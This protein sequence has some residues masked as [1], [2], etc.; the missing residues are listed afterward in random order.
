MSRPRLILTILVR[1]EADIIAQNVAWHLSQG[2][3]HVIVT[4]NGSSDGTSD[5]LRPFLQGG[6]LTLLHEPSDAYLQ[7][8]WTTRMALMARDELGADWIIC[9]DA[10]EFWRAPSG[11]LKDALPEGEDAPAML[12]CHRHN[13]I[14][15]RDALE[16]GPWA[17][18]LVYRAV[19]PPAMVAPPQ[20][21]EELHAIRFEHPYFQ[22]RLPPKMLFR[23]RGLTSIARG[24]HGGGYAGE[25][26]KADSAVEILHYPIRSRRAF[27]ASVRQIGGAMR[28]N[29][30]TALQTSWKYRRWLAMT[31]ASG[32]IWPA[33][34]EALPDRQ[35]LARD[36]EAGRL[37]RDLSM[38]EALA[39]LDVPAP[40]VEG[41]A[42]AVPAQRVEPGHM[43]SLLL[44][45][46]P[47]AGVDAALAELLIARGATP[48]LAPPR[49][50][51]SLGEAILVEMGRGGRDLRAAPKGWFDRP[52][53]R[54]YQQTL[55]EAL[56]ESFAD[57]N[58]AVVHG[59]ELAALLPLW[60]GIARDWQLGL[61]TVLAIGN[62]SQ[63]VRAWHR[64]TGLPLPI[65]ALIW[66]RRALDAERHSRGLPRVIVL[67]DDLLGDW[68][69]CAGA[70]EGQLGLTA[71]APHRAPDD[72]IEALISRLKA[73]SAATVNDALADPALPDFV[74][75]VFETLR[76]L[77]A[78]PETDHS[79]T[80]DR[81][82]ATLDQACALLGPA[83]ASSGE[84]EAEPALQGQ[85][86]A[87]E[88]S[89][90]LEAS[91]TQ[92]ARLT[93]L[94]RCRARLVAPSRPGLRQRAR[95][96]LSGSDADVRAV[97]EAPEF[98]AEWYRSTYPDV[99]AHGIDP[100]QHFLRFGAR[101]GRNPGPG[102]DTLRYY[103]ANP[104]VLECGALAFLHYIRH[105]REEGRA[106]FPAEPLPV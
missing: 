58:D 53:A 44:V 67:H 99:S 5:A 78:S 34:A 102:F 98:D 12:T 93:L 29:A 91:Q 11:N 25:A 1:D 97:R 74:K 30:G 62:P 19:D 90:A 35:R 70:L 28:R 94:L 77:A 4:D 76:A 31:E 32:S 101:E 59:P 80:L 50:L 88:T 10:D 92:N 79:T 23:A 7:D 40:M 86:D 13:M 8:A 24:A 39:Q 3:D 95:D 100:A 36:V 84:V 43:G 69:A 18:R 65:G 64:A 26:T 45:T 96:R 46:G 33:F 81:L 72:Q 14:C 85:P 22:Y 55:F 6:A 61:R 60:E 57:L 42:P 75:E 56:V 87:T 48:P 89:Q 103:E 15:P 27:E 106:I 2:V 52:I 38:S 16:T 9:S 41:E 83:L 104:D 63:E 21:M 47:D 17:D 105:G 51:K 66:A 49:R 71:P 37:V 82:G 54:Q 20:T 73:P 68:R